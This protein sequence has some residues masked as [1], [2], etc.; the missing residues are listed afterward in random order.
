VKLLLTM[1]LPYLPAIGGANKANRFLAEDFARKGHQIVV[2]VPMLGTPGRLTPA[3][4]L[5]ALTAQG[6]RVTSAAG[7]NSFNLNGV[8]VHA[9]LDPARLRQHLVEQIHVF[10]PDWIIVSSED[11]SQN[12]LEASIKARPDRI[13]Y[14][15][16]TPTFLPFGP[17][18]FFPSQRR[19]ELIGQV[20]VIVSLSRFLK[21]YIKTWSGLESHQ[22]YL[23]AYGSGPFPNFGRFDEGFVTLVN[24]CQVKGIAIFLALACALPD[25]PFAAVPT[26]GTTEADL[27]ALH[28]LPNI[29]LLEPAPDIDRI[30][31]QTRVLL[32]P[33]LWQ[34]NFPLTVVEAMLRGIPV[35][36][37]DVGGMREAKLGTNFVLPVQPITRFTDQ[38]DGNLLPVPIVL[39]QDTSA[40]RAALQC[41]LSDQVIYEQ[42]SAE[43]RRV[44]MQFV[45][46][47]SI[48]PLE[49]L[50]MRRS[51]KVLAINDQVAVAAALADTSRTTT[52]QDRNREQVAGLSPEQR[53]L[54]ML[55]LR[56]R[57]S[58]R[59]GPDADSSTIRPAPRDQPPPLSFAQQ[60][61]WFLDQLNPNSSLYNMPVALRLN[62]VLDV[63]A[64]HRGLRVLIARHEVLRTIF[65]LVDGQ[66]MQIIA[67]PHGNGTA[68]PSLVLLDLRSVAEVARDPLALRLA[69]IEALNPFD[70][71][72]GPL[73]R[74]GLV[75]LGSSEHILL[76]TMHH[77]ISDGWSMSV[78]VR[79]LIALYQA[80]ATGQPVVLPPLSIQYAD[81]AI[82]QRGWLQGAALDNHLGYWR[83][84]LAGLPTLDLPTDYPRPA[85]LGAEGALMQRLLPSALHQ[86]LVA[87]SHR[88]GITL[89]MTLLA[90]WLML[91]ARYSGQ[92]DLAVGTPIAGRTY[93]EVENLIGFFVN[94]LVL[95]VALSGNTNVRELLRQV[96]E[97]TL[98]AYTHQELPFERLVE[99][100]QPVRDFSRHPL[101]QILFALQNAPIS[102]LAVPELTINAVD[103]PTTVAKFDLTITLSEGPDGLLTVVNYQTGLFAAPVIAR[104]LGQFQTLLEGMVSDAKRRLVDLPLLRAA[105][106][107]QLLVEWN[108]PGSPV[109]SQATEVSDVT[110]EAQLLPSDF[111]CIHQLFEAQAA[112]TP[113][114]IA[115]VFEAATDSRNQ[116]GAGRKT[117][118]EA[119][120][121]LQP[122]ALSLQLTYA[123]LNVRANQLAHALRALGVG[124]EIPVG[125]FAERSIEM[126][127][128]LFGVLKAGGAYVGLDPA[129]PPQRLAYMIEDARIPIILTQQR[130][131]ARLPESPGCCVCLDSGWEQIARMSP[132][133]PTRLT[134][135]DNLAYVI[136]TSGSTGWPKGVVG[137]HRQLLSYL[138]G[139]TERLGSF[140][141]ER[142]AMQQTLAVDAPITNI[143]VSLCSGGSLHVL[144]DA[145]VADGA[146]MGGYFYRHQIDF[147]KVAPSHLRALLD[148]PCPERVVPRHLLLVGGEAS[149]W[150][151][152]QTVGTLEP[153]C[154]FVNHYGPTETTCGVSTY[155]AEGRPA[156]AAPGAIPIGRPLTTVGLYVLDAQLQPVPIG[157]AGELFVGGTGL[158]RGYMNRP[159]LT[160]ERFVPNPFVHCRLQI[161]DCRLADSAICNLQSAIC[162]R[163]Y[164]T[165][166]R[167][168]YQGDGQLVYLGRLDHQIKIR[169]FR[170]ELG[171]IEA[172]LS[173]HPA[174]QAAAVVF[175]E[176]RLEDR[177]LVAYVVPT[178]D[179]GRWTKDESGASSFVH[180]PS[181][182]ANELRAFLQ[183][184]LP[185]YMIPLVFVSL[186]SLPRTSQGKVNRRALPVPE[187]LPAAHD[188]HFTPP[189]TPDEELL[190]GIWAS[191]LGRPQVG[192]DAN[193]FALGGHSL[194]AT[195]IIARLR[196][197]LQVELPLRALF[198]TPTVAGL[199][200]QVAQMRRNGMELPPPIRRA[201]REERLPL[202][203]A[204][205]RLWLLDQLEPHSPLYNTAMAWQIDGALA[206][207]ALWHSLTTLLARHEILRTAFPSRDGEPYQQI[208]PHTI[209]A[210]PLLDLRA[211]SAPLRAA[212]MRS[213][214]AME[215]RRPFD[216]ARGPL[217][218]IVLLHV[219]DQTHMLLLTMHHIISDAWSLGV[220][221]RELGALYTAFTRGQRSP[222][223]ELPI[224]YADYAVWQRDWLQ[225]AVLDRQLTYWREQ[226][227]D[228]PTLALPTEAPR[229][230]HL[231]VQGEVQRMQLALPL[232]Q[233]LRRLSQRMGTTLFMTLLAGWLALLSRYSAQDDIVVGA[234]IAN[235]TQQ[236]TEGLIGFF[237]N[238]LVLRTRLGGNPS[239]YEL[240]GRVREVT[241]GAYAHQDIPFERLVEELQPTRDLNR[242]PLFQVMIELHNA[243]LPQVT[244]PGLA[245]V[246]FEVPGTVAK[247]DLLV[248]LSE[249]AEGLSVIV[250]Y[251]PELFTAATIARMLGHV[252]TLLAEMVADPQRM[253]GALPLLTEAER[254]QVLWEWNATAAEYPRAS[255][256]AALFTDQVAC[257][258]DAVALVFVSSASSQQPS[259]V[260]GA[261]HLTYRELDLRASA[262]GQHLRQRGV[263][264]DVLVGICVERSLEMLVAI[265][266]VLKAGGA[267]LPLDATYPQARLA[268]MLH[269]SHAAV[270]LAAAD[271][272]VRT[273]A[274]VQAQTTS[275]RAVV[276]LDGTPRPAD[277]PSAIRFSNTATIPF[278]V[279]TSLPALAHPDHL[280]YMMYTSGSTGQPKGVPIRHSNAVPFFVW[281]QRYFGLRPDD[282]ILQYH[283]LSFD[284]ST[285]EIFEALLAG[286]ALYVV[287][288][289]VARDVG[290]L[291]GMLAA[292]RITML[293]MTPSQFSALTDYIERTQPAA[294][295]ELRILVLGGELLPTAL[296]R[297]AISFVRRTCQVYNEYGPTETTISSSIFRVTDAALVQYGSLRSMPIGRPI[298][299]TQFYLLDQ[300]HQPVPVGI[301]GELYIGGIGLASAYFQRPALTAERFVPNP[302]SDCRLQIADCRLRSSAICNLQS[303]MG[304]R[305]YK[306][307]DL[308][309]WLPDGVIEFL[310]RADR[311]VKLRGYRI[312]VGEIESVL[313]R[314]PLIREAVVLVL[315]D[316]PGDQRL[317]AYVVP[318]SVG[319]VREPPLPDHSSSF[320]SR[321]SSLG[322][323][324]R[325]FLREQLPD[326][327]IPSAFVLL[328]RLPLTPNGKIDWR[329]L[330]TSDSDHGADTQPIVPPQ[331]P[332][333]EILVN[334]WAGVLGRESLNIHDDFFD[335]GGHSLLATQVI[336]RVRESFQVELP[337]RAL[338]E[339]PTIAG[340]A[341]Q[342]AAARRDPALPLPPPLRPADRS[343]RLPLSFAQQRLWFLDQ[344]Q[345][346]S[347]AY[348]IGTTWHLRGPLA[349]IPFQRSLN[350]L[351][352]RHESLRTTF[353]IRDGQPFQQIAPVQT[354][355]VPLL[356][357]RA[358]PK[359]L[360]YRN[361][362]ELTSAA[363]LRSFDLAR[364]P[365]LCVLLLQLETDAH[366]LLLTM[367]HIISDGWSMAVLIRELVAHYQA[368]LS[369]QLLRPPALSIQY[370]DYA[371]WQRNWLQG[372]V[373]EHQRSYWRTQLAD[374]PMLDLPT[375]H[376]RQLGQAATGASAHTLLD[377]TLLAELHTLSR[378]TNTTLFMILLA[379]WLTLLARYSRQDD[380]AVGS[381]IAG[382]TQRATEELI[383]F[384]VNTLVLRTR[385]RGNP[386]VRELIGR[387]REV[388]LG[389]YAHQDLPFERLV[390]ELQPARDLAQQPL[391]QV[392]I[393]L[394][395]APEAQIAVPGLEVAP[396]EMADGVAKFDLTIMLSEAADGLHMTVSYPPGRF[397]A[398][399]IM[400]MLGHART[401]LG[402]LV[403]DPTQRIGDLHLL[404]EAERWQLLTDWNRPTRAS[405]PDACIHHLFAVHA[406]CRPDAIALIAPD[407][408]AVAGASAH[409]TYAALDQYANQFAH[410]LQAIGVGAEV[411]V[412]VALDRSLALVI[413]LLGILKAGGAYVPLDLSY[414]TDQLAFIL[415]NT[416]ASVLITTKESLVSYPSTLLATRIVV[417][418]HADWPMITRHPTTAPDSTVT[419]DG[420]AYIIYTS[421]STG[422]PRGSEVP[423]RSIPGYMFGVSY[424]QFDEKQTWLQHSALMWDALTLELWSALLNGGRCV[425]FPGRIPLPQEL[426][427][428]LQAQGVTSVWLTAALFNL[429]VDTAPAVLAQLSQVL[430]GGEA[431][432]VAHMQ[433]L[434]ERLPTLQLVNGYGPSE[435]TVFSTCYQIP[436]ALDATAH[437]IPI[438]RAIGDRQV[439]VLD[440]RFALVPVGVPGELCVG[441]PALARGYL[442]RSD[443]TAER[444]VP[445][446]FADA[447]RR[448]QDESGLSSCAL[449]PSSGT[450]LY[451]TGDLVRYRPDGN[452]E[453]LGRI[454]QQTK[455]RGVRIEPGEIEAVLKQHPAVRECAVVV[456]EKGVGDKQLVAYVVQGSADQG[457]GDASVEHLT[458]DPRRGAIHRAPTGE[459]RAFLQTKL[460]TALV[461]A[462]FVAL[463][464]LPLT[465][466]GKV[467]RQALP[468]PESRQLAAADDPVQPRDRLE[469]R[470]V[471]IWEEVLDVRSIGRTDTFFELG[472]HS[473]LA[474]R[475]KDRIQQ[476]LGRN[477]P[478][479]LFFQGATLQDMADVLRQ[480]TDGAVVSPLVAIQPYGT[481]PPLF[482]VHPGLG[483]VF[484]YLPLARLL[485]PDQP[486]YGLR[487][488]G[489]E[490]ECQPIARIEQ[491]AE[492]YLE[493]VLQHQPHGPYLLSGWSF[494]G[495]VAF[496]MAQ[497]LHSR[498][499]TVHL[500][501]L[502]DA[503]AIYCDHQPADLASELMLW[504]LREGLGTAY[505]R[506]MERIAYPDI[507]HL[508]VDEQLDYF[509][510]LAMQENLL[511]ASLEISHAR[512]FA[513]VLRGNILALWRYKPLAYP[514]QVQL[515]RC[516]GAA[517][518]G[519][520]RDRT[521]GWEQYA[522]EPITIYSMPGEHSDLLS[523]PAISMLVAQLSA[524]ITQASIC[525]EAPKRKVGA[526]T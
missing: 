418:P 269:D 138:Q 482:C 431:L 519:V 115:L 83:Q 313:L 18:A 495:V 7:V 501:A 492:Y 510:T 413:A 111:S 376:P 165:G 330:H 193:F 443:L 167:V 526:I 306:T 220:L 279:D 142:F 118:D 253:I 70:L 94:T 243:P 393:A 22:V 477:V 423:H 276:C 192:V 57:A 236:A 237:V 514:G 460:P 334:I 259:A 194:L 278:G 486:L 147:F 480:Q 206:L 490:G 117:K 478:L 474:I 525:A 378:R 90:G 124:P 314:F 15:V 346:A 45:S 401:L 453:F 326:Y 5:D 336:A 425:L 242:H 382:R 447:G 162:N 149:H 199:A 521:L 133:N 234:P 289:S 277:L 110:P 195:R 470:L 140:P 249:S 485:G 450:R 458:P 161:A 300:Q 520:I 358:L 89:F 190:A 136:Y 207:V 272:L 109:G 317:V 305:L 148:S 399:T 349:R 445:N 37:S 301:P 212:T 252:T 20:P 36:A 226:L 47:L 328:N 406:T 356:D 169:G 228:L 360:R 449:C 398:A 262:L 284:F 344:L 103:L 503:S 348:S 211:L 295:A 397:E 126:I 388:T 502:L 320:V 216:L 302:F 488:A 270:L 410:H 497:Q 196:E 343:A 428:L 151:L 506:I 11:P 523:E 1:N 347:S 268:Y 303:A 30:F 427:A 227:A 417:D 434:R 12:L 415:A 46:G 338:F 202:S 271:T 383:G 408:H 473:L 102:A 55:R 244:V 213:L 396:F 365:L 235:R 405:P 67:P 354:V 78:L 285:W 312:E 280:A 351:V 352:A 292:A 97:V 42:E 176:R 487:A 73:L 108:A 141:G 56:K 308:A 44:A 64:L 49:A 369:G 166:D 6:L 152:R 287:P 281:Y 266:G 507:R 403:A 122:A 143:Y 357:L 8:E 392:M 467:D 168:R 407:A 121:S 337:L 435:C 310:G 412:G 342:L 345:P 273:T 215:A 214:A 375:D 481:K 293:N 24:P 274:L 238:T 31:A 466:T 34:E 229:P 16:H 232:L 353:P 13:A 181:S 230:L 43:S 221:I 4:F 374:L 372:A 23:P 512:H 367:H 191:V 257:T 189:R 53:A 128:G 81:Y 463:D 465:S 98:A 101:F 362:R 299:N 419:A 114:A 170:I 173:Q 241:L 457:S 130:L 58:E 341:T 296:A 456:R 63:A 163:L 68:T 112:R 379:G 14:I 286:A 127:L 316:A 134:N 62:G 95:R 123:E 461:P 483:D 437:T 154:A 366:V 290:A 178:T 186:D 210:L 377:A 387:V 66:P 493:A 462:V 54:L 139:I 329:A 267:F 254:A 448:M 120:F 113:D 51:T 297:R 311:Q 104:I 119:V 509:L 131:L 373:L 368:H 85:R 33:S 208:A 424:A 307:G 260:P 469:M 391:F 380:L 60:R 264:P 438:G 446:P 395:N 442:G 105:E 275:L 319:A 256:L 74:V 504:I 40:W 219:A 489:L 464:Q 283:S 304:E 318:V 21:N 404:T 59:A 452:I 19:T 159:D 439:Y 239:V 245:V 180:R 432:S 25:Q 261:Q 106:R 171:E 160:A 204:Q 35:V 263:G 107:H 38:L 363:S 52:H 39:Q 17:Q 75:R 518:S 3:Q 182:M 411:R 386:S 298:G 61:L 332:E 158:A 429:I 322:S 472:G 224:Q 516:E 157:V 451:R 324:L 184:R 200:E 491:M 414:P 79:E 93:K 146:A 496:E 156:H 71:A 144:S 441:G 339:S 99:E 28:S 426:G 48:A 187:E 91:L 385:L 327:M 309:R 359:A 444:F 209:L 323:E 471:Q 389:A 72:R 175:H 364:G 233:A 223:L 468:K 164:R 350:E 50:L 145:R 400:R 10:E 201:A 218:R 183:T 9:V 390:E 92:D 361:A 505:N 258:P 86:E 116:P 433:R 265:L 231:G 251:Q 222:L 76:L 371:L 96:R 430:T 100:L 69:T 172:T 255:S 129:M 26:W 197:Q 384:F 479:S 150:D 291:A 524:A 420:L 517:R 205:Q 500:L 132:I 475:L 185:E 325:A 498:G 455:I 321:P 454:D 155:R 499:H 250:S 459:L 27:T 370:A 402:T 225:G 282:H 416:Q 179:E 494:G 246:P 32:M 217:L 203:F 135:S 137:E 513:R 2:V 198:E 247:F 88:E 248:T 240:L 522:T 82:W 340:M 29:T 508:G 440:A 381:P 125:I 153:G 288:S 315:E 80:Q 333:E 422:T 65:A 84:Q 87:L 511:P 355:P 335:L 174:V 41:L 409:L 436:P 484:A 394:Q 294:L 77:S 421:G 476:L 331:T 177:Y 188:G 515:F